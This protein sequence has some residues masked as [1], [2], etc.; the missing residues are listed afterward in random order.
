MNKVIGII[1][2]L[3]IWSVSAK[4]INSPVIL[5]TPIE[6]GKEFVNLLRDE[7]F[8]RNL[9]S[10]I[11]KSV[12]ASLLILI[13]GIP[14]GMIIGFSKTI[15]Y[16]FRPFITILQSVPVISWLA[17][18]IFMWGIGWKGPI[19][20][21]T[22]SLLPIVIINTASGMSNIDRELIE[23]AKIYNVSKK[24]TI[25]YIYLGSIV[26]FIIASMEVV[27]GNIWKTILVTEYLCGDSG[28]GVMIA[29][30]RS[31]IDTPQIFALTLVAVLLAI[32]M[33][34]LSKLII[35]RLAKRWKLY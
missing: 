34:Y 26:P 16:I 28:I 10:T 23:V 22:M 8:Y 35:K 15:Y 20:I 2:I 27:F 11:N 12:F 24:K 17:F 14:I 13:L 6:V 7:V 9:L 19:F 4:I 29:W 21:S 1:C 25:I 5:P 3:I 31:Y 33:E 32:S 18:A 30:A